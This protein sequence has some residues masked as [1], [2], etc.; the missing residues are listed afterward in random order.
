[1]GFLRDFRG[2]THIDGLHR[3]VV[4]G[5]GGMYVLQLGNL[6]RRGPLQT[7][8]MN[9][10]E[11]AVFGAPAIMFSAIIYGEQTRYPGGDHQDWGQLVRRRMVDHQAT[12]PGEL[13]QMDTFRM[14]Q[15]HYA[16]AWTLVSLLNRQPAKFGKLLLAMRRG[17]S[18]AEA[19]EKV[20]GWDEKKLASQWRAFVMG[21][22]TKGPDAAA[23]QPGQQ[24]ADAGAGCAADSAEKDTRLSMKDIQRLHR[25]RM[26]PEQL[27]EKVAEQGRA[28]EVTAGVAGE[29]HSLGFRPAQID[30]VRESSSEPLV[31]GKWLTISDQRRDQILKGMKQIAVE[32]GADIEPIESQ[33]VTLWAAKDIQR[34][35]LPDLLK[36]ERFFHTKC[37]EPI[38]SGLDKRSTHVVLLK[39]H[40]EYEAWW[41]TMF[42]IFGTQLDKKD[43][44]V[45][46]AHLR[47]DILKMRV[48]QWPDICTI[49][50]GELPADFVHRRVA[51]GVAYQYIA[52]TGEPLRRPAANRFHQRS[53]DRRLRIAQR[54]G[55]RDRLRRTAWPPAGDQ[56]A[57][58]LLVRRRMAADQA[59]PLGALLKMDRAAMRNRIMPSRGRWW[60]F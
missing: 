15:P 6:R 45:A 8:F 41:R 16:E 32:S 23:A 48:F 27:A 56:Q 12:P 55:R 2:R 39:D 49:S 17:V 44:P 5:V 31:P 47:D 35:Y 3:D 43:N 25:Q 40:A 24:S 10:A 28:F 59:T 53:R 9:D 58:G 51:A 11:T 30:T 20:Y 46:N 13:L 60:S 37:A 14:S 18:E 36:L 22:E 19:V 1:M 21:Q 57:W 7:G 4:A 52:T 42:K 29:L 54:D 38:R 50:V 34:T 26:W 33:H